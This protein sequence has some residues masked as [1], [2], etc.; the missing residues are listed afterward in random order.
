MERKTTLVLGAS[1]NERRYS[2]MAVQL[3]NERGHD[4]YAYAMRPGMINNIEITTEWPKKNSIDTVAMYVSPARQ[5]DLYDKILTLSPRRVIFNPGTE[6]N[7]LAIK[8]RSA[9]IEVVMNCTL[10]MLRG[11]IY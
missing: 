11:G 6:N 7:D 8:L 10:I 3:L 2:N 9:N 5:S 4:V 1:A